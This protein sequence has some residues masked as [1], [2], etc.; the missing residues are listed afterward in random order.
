MTHVSRKLNTALQGA[1][2]GGGDPAT[3]PLY[4]FGPFLKLVVVAGVANI[5]FGTSIWLVIITIATVS[6]MYRLVMRWITDG[7]GG[8]GL[9][10]E[11]F[12]GWAVK[13]NAGITFIEYTLTFLVS[14]AALVTFAADRIHSLNDTTFL[15]ENRTWLAVAMSALTAFLVN[16]GPR[17]AARTFG[18][19]TGAILVLL[20]ILIVVTIFK[21]GFELP[22]FELR[23]FHAKYISS[24][25]GGFSRIL[26]VMTGIE[27][28]ANLVAAYDGP[29]EK[30]SKKA[31]QSLMI[32]MGTTGA[33][34]LILGPAIRFYSDP[35][36]E[37]VSVFTQTMDALL[38]KW[39]S[40]IGTFL[41]IAV[42]LSAAAASALGLQNLFVGLRLRHYVPPTLARLNKFGVAG[43]PVI[44]EASIASMFFIILGTR[45]E[46]YL[47]LYAAGVF[48]L[49]SMTGWAATKRLMR[50]L[51]RDQENEHK[52]HIAILIIVGTVAA[53]L[54][55]T[56]ATITIFIERFSEGAWLYFLMIPG[57]YLIFSLARKAIGPPTRSEERA[58][59]IV[60]SG[61]GTDADYLLWEA[62]AKH[63][64]NSFLIPISGSDISLKALSAARS[65][66]KVLIADIQAVVVDD[67]Q[68]I[69]D[70]P[71]D[72]IVLKKEKTVSETLV[73]VAHEKDID[74]IIMS[75]GDDTGLKKVTG[76]VASDVVRRSSI[77]VMVL[78]RTWSSKGGNITPRKIFVTLDGSL[79]SERA[80]PYAINIAKAYKSEIF[81]V[82]IPGDQH[83]ISHAKDYGKAIKDSLVEHNL[84]IKVI[85]EGSEPTKDIARLAESNSADLIIM[86]TSARRGVKKFIVGSVADS[87]IG[88]V[89]IPVLLVAIL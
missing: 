55:T 22:S 86:A 85:V 57:M 34:M 7:S 37:K 41:G 67:G 56:G 54:L 19:A 76:S 49:L 44:L 77:P 9:A 87:V 71:D 24:T 25:L 45:E 78:P 89:S 30:R 18:P 42:L 28:F 64:F 60:E 47:A 83:A 3:S 79:G 88:E 58:A 69:P 21:R 38:P 26:A 23:A 50:G 73:D 17:M 36:N 84:E 43:R 39:A 29:P 62:E 70:L 59:Y 8:S 65:L 4:V 74:L 75:A 40:T 11:E 52:T 53:S 13:I 63:V 68:K 33:A 51:K 81:I 27:V 1:L 20:W 6:M 72:V 66:A 15:F 5:T 31:F 48:V 61:I 2:A 80:I 46:T 10:E 32:I 82:H 16:R 14:I 35:L 12:G